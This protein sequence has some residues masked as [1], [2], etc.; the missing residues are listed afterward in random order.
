MAYAQ[1]VEPPT[2]PSE[3]DGQVIEV[4]STTHELDEDAV[5]QSTASTGGEDP[6]PG[7]GGG[8]EGSVRG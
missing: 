7:R 4:L 8:S 3:L 5:T 1:P 2:V 6:A